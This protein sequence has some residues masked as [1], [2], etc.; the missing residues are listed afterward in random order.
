[1]P[2][3]LLSASPF[4]QHEHI[5]TLLCQS[6]ATLAILEIALESEPRHDLVQNVISSVSKQ[7]DQCQ[8]LN[9]VLAV[10]CPSPE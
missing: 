9:R 3:L 5:N 8:Q 4:E 2:A 1:M 6:N 10:D 7:L